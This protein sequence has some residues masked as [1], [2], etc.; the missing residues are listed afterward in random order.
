MLRYV[1]ARLA[2]MVLVMLLVSAC[3]FVL[4]RVLPGDPVVAMVGMMDVSASTLA[5]MRH[6]LGL[7]RPL[8]VQFVVWLGNVAHGNLGVSIRSR[9]PVTGVLLSHVPV[10]LEL[11]AL[12][13]AVAV[14]V[15]I[16]F[17]MLAV[18]HHGRWLDRMLTAG[19]LVGVSFPG[20]V[21]ALG[22]IYLMSLRLRWLPPTGYVSPVDDLADNLKLMI[23]PT[24]TL[25]LTS[26]GL[27][28]R[29]L[30][31]QLLEEI[32]HGYV[33][34]ARA[35]GATERAIMVSHVL[36]NALVP[37]TTVLGNEAGVLLSGAVITETIFALPGVGRLAVENVLNRDL[38]VIQ[39]V[40]LWSALLYLSINL[41]VDLIY[42]VLDPRVR[43]G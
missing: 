6:S 12:S 36:R 8:P 43:Y 20:F 15:A 35:K 42:G 9:E 41:A 16:P 30:R 2:A 33:R 1:A 34:T 25:G 38:P 26:A 5:G 29:L 39:G 40:V 13:L 4:M 3:V 17:A 19:S 24:L 28:T 32:S 23:M 14:M 37:F 10:T 7:D 21:L 22:L 31:G 11:A 27:L 18:R